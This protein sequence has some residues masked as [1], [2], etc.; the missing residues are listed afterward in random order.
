MRNLA[1]ELLRIHQ[2]H[3][4]L[5]ARAAEVHLL[6]DVVVCF[7]RNAAPRRGSR[8]GAQAGETLGDERQALEDACRGAV[9]GAIRRRV[10]SFAELAESVPD[11]VVLIFALAPLR[12]GKPPNS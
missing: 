12:G 6:P 11:H 8:A 9:E 5:D 1:E 10:V 7:I 2:K 4:D 3:R